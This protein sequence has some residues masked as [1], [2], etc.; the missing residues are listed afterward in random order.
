MALTRQVYVIDDKKTKNAF[1]LPGGKIFVFTGILPVSANDDGLATVL[2]HEVAHQVARHPAERMS[3]M[4]VR[5]GASYRR[6]LTP[7]GALWAR[8]SARIFRPG[9][10]HHTFDLD[11][12]AAVRPEGALIRDENLLTSQIAKFSEIRIRGRFYR[13]APHVVSP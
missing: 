13:I 11:L 3:S 5:I 6:S 7:P 2:G 9:C 4:K 8:L 12:H 1:V 10:R